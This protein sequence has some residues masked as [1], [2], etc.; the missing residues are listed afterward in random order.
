MR[1]LGRDVAQPGSASHWGCGG[2]RFESSRPDQL[3]IFPNQKPRFSSTLRTSQHA[4]EK[5]ESQ[6]VH[7][8]VH[9]DVHIPQANALLPT[10]GRSDVSIYRRG[11]T[12]WWRRR[13]S[14]GNPEKLSIMLRITLKTPD[15]SVARRVALTLDMELEMVAVK[16]PT[17]EKCPDPKMIAAVYKEALEYKR[18]HIAAIQGRPPFNCRA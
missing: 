10:L 15:K 18:N 12:Y 16:F 3:I 6:V 8:P 13:V 4:V 5:S 2:R 7:L 9:L 17:Q 14:L 11:P 1:S